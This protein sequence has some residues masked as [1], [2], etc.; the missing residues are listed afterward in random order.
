MLLKDN[1]EDSFNTCRRVCGICSRT[2]SERWF[3]LGAQEHLLQL[4]DPAIPAE[5]R[6]LPD[7]TIARDLLD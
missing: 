7:G 2:N 3:V 4:N 6:Y 1:T 5:V